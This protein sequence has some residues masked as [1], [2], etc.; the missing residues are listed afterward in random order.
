MLHPI[1][2]ALPVLRSSTAE[3]GRAVDESGGRLMMAEGGKPPQNR[4]KS[5]WFE[6]TLIG[7]PADKKGGLTE[8]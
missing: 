5:V 6:I 4:W 7:L 8:F 1:H 3:G 2:P